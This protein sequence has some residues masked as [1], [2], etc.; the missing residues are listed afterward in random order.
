MRFD[1]FVWFSVHYLSFCGLS[2][3]PYITRVSVVWPLCQVITW[4]CAVWLV[5]L[6]LRTLPEFVR[7]TGLS[8]SPFITWVCVEHRAWLVVPWWK[9]EWGWKRRWHASDAFLGKISASLGRPWFPLFILQTK[10]KKTL[11]AKNPCPRLSSYC[12]DLALEIHWSILT[13]SALRWIVH[14]KWVYDGNEKPWDNQSRGFQSLI[15]RIQWHGR[16]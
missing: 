12:R 10:N 14:Y 6:V 7:K 11:Q 8:G 1:R 3:S 5:C 9:A 16:S 13:A 4:V 15:R 2:G